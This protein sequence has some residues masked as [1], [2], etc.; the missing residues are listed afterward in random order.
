MRTYTNEFA[1]FINT[2]P[3]T[4]EKET[5]LIKIQEYSRPYLPFLAHVLKGKLKFPFN[6]L[7]GRRRNQDNDDTVDESFMRWRQ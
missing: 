1:H 7:F 3:F 4:Q 2:G 5:T 6:L